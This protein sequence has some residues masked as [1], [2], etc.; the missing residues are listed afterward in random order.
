MSRPTRA[1][2]R[3]SAYLCE[4][5]ESRLLLYDYVFNGTAGGQSLVAQMSG[6][7]LVLGFYLEPPSMTIPNP[8]G[9]TVLMHAV[10]GDNAVYVSSNGGAHI[11]VD[12]DGGDN[13][14]SIGGNGLPGGNVTEGLNDLPGGTTILSGAASDKVIVYDQYTPTTH[15]YTI[16]DARFDRP[17]WGGMYYGDG[18]GLLELWTSP[19]YDAV[20][21]I[22]STYPNQSI[23]VRNLSYTP[24]SSDIMNVGNPLQGVQG[25]R[26][27]LYIWGYR[28][29]SNTININ[30][31]GNTSPRS[32]NFDWAGTS[33]TGA[34]SGLAPAQISWDN[35]GTA[36]LNLTTG[37][38]GDSIIVYRN[39]CPLTIDGAPSFTNDSIQI[40]SPLV[41]GMASILTPVTVENESYANLSLVD[42]GDSTGRNWTIDSAG[43]FGSLVGMA[44]VPIYWRS[45]DIASL[46]VQCGSGTDA[47]LIKRSSVPLNIN[48]SGGTGTDSITVG[49]SDAGGVQQITRDLKIDN[50]PAYSNLVIDDTGDA[51]PRT[52]TLDLVNST[53]N[54]LTGLAPATIRYDASDTKDVTIRT[55]SGGDTVNVLRTRTTGGKT[56]LTSSGGKDAVTLGNATNGL[57]SILG[58]AIE[59]TNPPSFTDITLDDRTDAV[60]RNI[61][62]YDSGGGFFEIIG[63]APATIRYKT[64]DYDKLKLLGGSAADTF[65]INS[66]FGPIQ[67]DT[68]P[69]KD[70]VFVGTAGPASVELINPVEDLA[71]LT[72]NANS[73][74]SLTAP[75]TQ[76]LVTDTLN[77]A[78][79]A[80]LDVRDKSVILNYSGGSPLV[81]IQNLIRTAR[82]G[83]AWDGYGITSNNA[84]ANPQHNTTLGAMSSS[85]YAAVHGGP[86]A[87]QTVAASAVL[88][89]YTYYGDANFDGRVTFDDYVRVDIGFAQHRTGWAN[90]DFNLDGVVNFD[91]YVLIDTAFNTQGAALGRDRG[92][93]SALGS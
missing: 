26:G 91:N 86:F 54:V 15:T 39:N 48:N 35:P 50:D 8:A 70:W 93:R 60:A 80:R 25:I 33:E 7:N 73:T 77:M 17:G 81:G 20:V 29:D 19:H 38:G 72:V 59:I 44:P 3:E 71:V 51:T 79:T 11:T 41:G 65:N 46:S 4:P 62:H 85:D 27:D 69:G 63:F 24:G 92:G 32:A 56:T 84:F 2:L 87:G 64:A 75:A 13:F 34:L 68:G 83:G 1:R 36:N 42:S 66:T 10:G 45:F 52:A 58:N 9:K 21:N 61:S 16:T 74:A 88:I 14:I 55:G 22:E 57:Q 53:Y 18:I 23:A 47:G 31:T 28:D 49:S 78:A 89:K 30:D 40:G 37:N 67:L 82:N 90:G 5:L 12:A 6:A 76:V 43:G